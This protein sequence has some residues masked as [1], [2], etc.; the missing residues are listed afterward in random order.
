LLE[1][2]RVLQI[3]LPV[4]LSF[5]TVQ[6]I[7]YLLDVANNRLPPETSLVRFSLYIFYFPKLLSGPVERAKVF[8]PRLLNPLIVDRALLERSASL[9]LVGL[10]R[11]IV[12]ANSLFNMIPAGAFTTPLDY[13]GQKINRLADRVRVRALQRFCWI[14]CHRAGCKPLVWN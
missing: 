3:L 7:S 1:P 6:N 2:G 10:F 11:K 13:P 9:I 5:L 8:L 12:L 4:G 14:Y